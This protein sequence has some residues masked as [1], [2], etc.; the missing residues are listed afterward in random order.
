LWPITL[1][2]GLNHIKVDNESE[3]KIDLSFGSE[4]LSKD[5]KQTIRSDHLTSGTGMDGRILSAFEN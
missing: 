1:I 5:E 2:I 3:K 4:S